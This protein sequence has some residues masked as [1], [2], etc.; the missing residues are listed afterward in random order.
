M[1][2]SEESRYIHTNETMNDKL[3]PLRRRSSLQSRLSL[4]QQQEDDLNKNLLARRYSINTTTAGDLFDDDVSVTSFVLPDEAFHYTSVDI[5][6]NICTVSQQETE[7]INDA[8]DDLIPFT[9]SSDFDVNPGADAVP[10][11]EPSFPSSEN[12]LHATNDCI[13]QNTDSKDLTCQNS[14]PGGAHLHY[15]PVIPNNIGLPFHQVWSPALYKHPSYRYNTNHIKSERFISHSPRS[16]CLL[17]SMKKS[18]KTQDLIRKMKK[19]LKQMEFTDKD[20]VQ[21]LM[22]CMQ[23]TKKSRERIHQMILDNL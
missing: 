13:P 7:G 21:E 10:N 16:M 23:D 6:R 1:T 19:S 4:D 22:Y 11:L 14:T 3:D 8:D 17:E 18:K 5:F 15:P 2:N 12:V 20:A 9:L